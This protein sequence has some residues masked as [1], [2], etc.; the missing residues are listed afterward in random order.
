MS[1]ATASL[2]AAVDAIDPGGRAANDAVSAEIAATG[3][4]AGIESRDP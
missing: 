4:T 3:E 2:L 1:R